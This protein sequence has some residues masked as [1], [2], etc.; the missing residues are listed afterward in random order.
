MESQTTHILLEHN[1]KVHSSK[2]KKKKAPEGNVTSDITD[3]WQIFRNLDINAVLTNRQNYSRNKHWSKP[4][5]NK[6]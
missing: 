1:F 6:S 5:N 2:K 4:L 3:Q